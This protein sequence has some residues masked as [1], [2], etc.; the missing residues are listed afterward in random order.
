MTTLLRPAQH[1]SLWY[2]SLA[3]LA[4]LT[5][6]LAGGCGKSGTA[7]PAIP[8]NATPEERAIL[9]ARSALGPE[10][11][12]TAVNTLV[13]A[14]VIIDSNNQPAGQVILLFKKP[15][16]QRSEMRAADQTI[17]LQGSDGIEGWMLS[18]DKKNNRNV[19]VLKAPQETQNI[20]MS[21]E[22]LY[23][24]RATEHV[25][26]AS[27]TMDGDV[28]Y[29]DAACWKVSFHYPNNFTYVRYIDRA[30]GQL[31]GTVLEPVGAEFI[32]Q[33]NLVVDGINFPQVL[34]SYNKNGQ[35]AQ[36]I[37]FQKILVNQPLDDR[38]FNMPSL[39][40]IYKIGSQAKP[41]STAAPSPAP[42]AAPATASASGLPKLQAPPLKPN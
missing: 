7:G 6:L 38:L 36:T 40:D 14:G 2:C 31:H 39:T 12:L 15:A 20:Y 18:I 29:H 41:Q 23:F 22:N 8:A 21:M 10:D 34:R 32:E 4:A 9:T 17:I 13:M 24:Y 26:G 16:R 33:G 19:S 37:Q 3:A 11:K 28:Q 25:T 30:N 35:L 1:S 27:V 5:A 42:A